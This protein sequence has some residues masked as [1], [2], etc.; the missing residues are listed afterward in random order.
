MY[1]SL[2]KSSSDSKH[3]MQKHNEYIE[4][5]TIGKANAICMRCILIKADRRDTQIGQTDIQTDGQT[6][7]P[8]NSQIN[9][10]TDRDTDKDKDSDRDRDRDRQ[11]DRDRQTDRQNDRMSCLV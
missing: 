10:K 1:E 9:R 5:L 8:T 7:R 3:R 4:N 11:I 2:L 6:D